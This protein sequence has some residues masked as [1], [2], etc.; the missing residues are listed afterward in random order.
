MQ[1]LIDSKSHRHSLPGTGVL[2]SRKLLESLGTVVSG[3]LHA[4]VREEHQ[5][6]LPLKVGASIDDVSG[7]G[8][9][10][11]R[12]TLCNLLRESPRA[13]GAW[14]RIDAT[15]QAE[16]VRQL[17]RRPVILHIE[18]VAQQKSSFRA[19][20]AEN[21]GRMRWI[22]RIFSLIIA[23]GVL[24]STGRLSILER[25]RDLATLRVLGYRT[26]ELHWMMASELMLLTLLAVP[27]GWVLGYAGSYATVHAFDRELFRIPLVVSPGTYL[28]AAGIVLAATVVIAWSMRYRIA[29]LDEV[30]VLKA[31]Q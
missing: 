31:R 29:R 15:R 6:L 28:Q 16:V 27:L 9:W 11:D 3:T 17:R 30:E 4:D 7:E 23:M 1:V 18:S 14:L 24:A 13:T 8:I 21:V 12:R 5:P 22:N 2:A 19:T 25:Q 20:I 10:I 26:G